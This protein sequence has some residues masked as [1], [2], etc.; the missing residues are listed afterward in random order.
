MTESE[1]DLRI[2]DD[3]VRIMTIADAWKTSE[4]KDWEKRAN[5]IA[6]KMNSGQEHVILERLQAIR[7]TGSPAALS[8]SY[9][10]STCTLLKYRIEKYSEADQV[11]PKLKPAPHG[12]LVDRHRVTSGALRYSEQLAKELC[13]PT[14]NGKVIISFDEVEKAGSVD[15]LNDL[16]RYYL[17]WLPVTA[18]VVNPD[19]VHTV[20]E[21][22]TYCGHKPWIV[23]QLMPIVVVSRKNPEE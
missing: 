11:R 4:P 17:P 7:E 19:G 2:I 23:S 1:I 9:L 6:R 13:D 8:E 10:N 16:L 12:P 21:K 20:R 18:T 14:R 15:A 5:N 22:N 3:V